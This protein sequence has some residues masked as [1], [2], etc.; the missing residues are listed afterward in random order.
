MLPSLGEIFG[1]TLYTYPLVMGFAWGLAFQMGAAAF[2]KS[3]S[4]FL[5][6]V[7]F[8]GTFLFAW[9]GAKVL[10]LVTSRQEQFLTNSNFWL[11]GGFVF[12]GGL[13]GALFFIVLFCRINKNFN[14]KYLAYL[15]PILL[16]AHGLGRI[17]C[18]LAG[19]CYG[20]ESELLHA[21]HPVQ[22][23]ESFS[24]I[25]F[26]YLL[27][28][29]LKKRD[30]EI[31]VIGLY[32]FAYAVLRFILEFFRGDQI[33]GEIGFLSTSQWISLA[34]LIPAAYFLTIAIRRKSHGL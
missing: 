23:Y 8:W 26:S 2:E 15:V 32:F 14:W 22:L 12:Y 27:N 24:L 11:G 20:K 6:N 30:N 13:I 3:L 25:F 18:F 33:R 21:R 34:L 29:F 19:C 28:R 17:G 10:F 7:F 9:L 31:L 5:W 1:I 16:L 4:P